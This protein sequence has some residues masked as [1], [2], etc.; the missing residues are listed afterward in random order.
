MNPEYVRGGRRQLQARLHRR[1][2]VIPVTARPTL[3]GSIGFRTSPLTRF[4]TPVLIQ[5]PS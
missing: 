5:S 3:S 1:P 4:L 2:S